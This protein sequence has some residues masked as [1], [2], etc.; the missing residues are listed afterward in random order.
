M[1]FS[2]NCKTKFYTTE[3]R[4]V[5]YC[6]ELVKMSN[7]Q[8]IIIDKHLLIVDTKGFKENCALCNRVLNPIIYGRW[9]DVRASFDGDINM[10]LRIYDYDVILFT[11]STWVFNEPRLGP[12]IYGYT[13]RTVKKSKFNM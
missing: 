4:W 13:T 3:N 9:P 2:C 10:P 1:S 11:N 7:I 6:S 12:F 5:Y 8:F